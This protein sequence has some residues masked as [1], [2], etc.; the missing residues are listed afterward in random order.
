MSTEFSL[1]AP[2]NLE[3]NKEVHILLIEKKELTLPI[4]IF[5]YFFLHE[6]VKGVGLNDPAIKNFF[7]ASLREDTHKKVV[8]LMVGPL[9]V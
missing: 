1:N 9:R 2:N 4:K 3:Y 5:L 8:F 6:R 7:V